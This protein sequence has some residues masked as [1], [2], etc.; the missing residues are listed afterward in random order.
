MMASNIKGLLDDDIEQSLLEELTASDQ[1]DFSDDDDS[2][3]TD[4]LT[5]V[6]VIGSECSDNESD[7]VQC[8]TESSAPVAS[9]ATFAWEDMTNYV[10]QREQ[11]VHKYGPQNEA[12]NETNCAKVF[13]MFVDEEL[14]ELIVRET[15]IYAAQKIQARRFIP[16]R[17]RMRDWKTVTKDEMYVVLALFMLMGIILKLTLHSYFLKNYILATPIFGSIISMDCF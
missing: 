1:S 7:D 17:S 6:E 5:V 10:G 15:N 13:K 4:Y 9:S 8:A 16:L 11:F 2:S 12:Q 14:V 3:G